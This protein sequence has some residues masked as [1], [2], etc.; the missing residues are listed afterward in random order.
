MKMQMPKAPAQELILTSRLCKSPVDQTQAWSMDDADPMTP[1]DDAGRRDFTLSIASTSCESRSSSASEHTAGSSAQA[2]SGSAMTLCSSTASSVN[3]EQ[4]RRRMKALRKREGEMMLREQALKQKE[5]DVASMMAKIASQPMGSQSSS[6]ASSEASFVCTPED[7][8]E[9]DENKSS[10]P[11]PAMGTFPIPNIPKSPAVERPRSAE[12]LR[13]QLM[14]PFRV[15]RIMPKFPLFEPLGLLVSPVNHAKPSAPR[16]T[17]PLIGRSP[18]A[19]PPFLPQFN[20]FAGHL[21]RNLLTSG[22]SEEQTAGSDGKPK[23]RV[24][25]SLLRELPPVPRG[26]KA[27]FAAAAPSAPSA[28][29]PSARTSQYPPLKSRALPPKVSSHPSAHVRMPHSNYVRRRSQSVTPSGGVQN[30]NPWR[31][32]RRDT[33]FEAPQAEAGQKG[34]LANTWMNSRVTRKDSSSRK[35]RAKGL[36]RERPSMSMSRGLEPRIWGRGKSGDDR[37]HSS[38]PTPRKGKNPRGS[39]GS[40][41]RS[42]ASSQPKVD[43]KPSFTQGIPVERLIALSSTYADSLPLAVQKL[44]RNH[45]ETGKAVYQDMK[46][47]IAKLCRKHNACHVVQTMLNYVD[48]GTRREISEEILADCPNLTT[49]EFG[50]YIIQ[51]IISMSD[52]ILPG[53]KARVMAMLEPN[54]IE[55]SMDKFSSNVV[56]CLYAYGSERLKEKIFCKMVQPAVLNKLIHDN[57]GNY[58]LQGILENSNTDASEFIIEVLED[59]FGAKLQNMTYGRFVWKKMQNVRRRIGLAPRRSSG[60]SAGWQRVQNAKPLRE[61]PVLAKHS[62]GQSSY[63]AARP[64]CTRASSTQ[65]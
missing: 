47:K 63:T 36:I 52:T 61:P 22:F 58:V 8:E 17:K 28:P 62:S 44:V 46:G 1:E 16:R 9:T 12:G 42:T 43:L 21:A 45:Q 18:L 39:A 20:A 31:T 6:M 29:N 26:P 65:S 5:R 2:S 40:Q 48:Y 7:E 13:H 34:R 51:H 4:I 33:T 50:N 57:F 59:N 23:N 60:Q 35:G 10:S 53:V 49:D 15:A 19:R 37:A 24:A 41:A 11:P 3:G 30:N 32:E 14:S 55:L 25:A 54:L 38:P 64:P 27:P 56:E